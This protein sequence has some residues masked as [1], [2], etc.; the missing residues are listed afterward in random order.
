MADLTPRIRMPRVTLPGRSDSASRPRGKRAKATAST[1]ETK[2]KAA[3]GAKAAEAKTEEATTKARETAK[4]KSP[5]P[6]LQERME[7]L[8]GWMAEIERK[9]G[10]L[11]YFGLAT[12]VL[13]ILAS[14]AALY[15]GLAAKSDKASKS[16]VDALTK[17]VDA[18][19]AAAT[20]NSKDTQNALNA[21][22]AQL[23]ASISALQRQ[24]AQNA[25]SISTLQSQASAGAFGKGAA[26]GTSPLTPGSTTTTTP[27]KP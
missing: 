8:Q 26:V 3:D 23:Q 9:Q 13:A 11:T 16:D 24:Q 1:A 15:F 21:S 22:A 2:P 4:G 18:L 6:N 25:A 19:Q 27:K 17:K 7:G 10:R 20:K 12:L 5:E 14:I